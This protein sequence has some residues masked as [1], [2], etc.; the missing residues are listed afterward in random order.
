MTRDP[1]GDTVDRPRLVRLIE[2]NGS[3]RWL[4]SGPL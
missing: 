4:G 1:F 3:A 2:D